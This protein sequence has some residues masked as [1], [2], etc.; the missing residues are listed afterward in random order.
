MAREGS[1][2]AK[3]PPMAPPDSRHRPAVTLAALVVLVAVVLGLWAIQVERPAATPAVRVMP[4]NVVTTGTAPPYSIVR[5]PGRDVVV[6]S[7]GIG[8]RVTQGMTFDVYD[9]QAGIPAAQPAASR[10]GSKALV[11][12]V[13]IGPGFSECRVVHRTP[14][15]PLVEGDLL[16]P[17]PAAAPRGPAQAAHSGQVP[18]VPSPD[19]APA[20]T[21]PGRS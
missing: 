9:K 21:N 6:I 18:P 17:S 20:G 11:E 1:A 2:E 16:V 4:A 10:S 8:D 7:G 12:V 5:T 14:G 19:P 15:M 3:I 13:R